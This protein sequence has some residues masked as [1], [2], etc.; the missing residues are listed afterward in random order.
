MLDKQ[1]ISII[2]LNI[3]LNTYGE[4]IAPIRFMTLLIFSKRQAAVR[5]EKQVTIIKIIFTKI[6]HNMHKIRMIF[7]I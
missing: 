1:K 6:Q 4:D 3:I 7:Y 2:L 5:A